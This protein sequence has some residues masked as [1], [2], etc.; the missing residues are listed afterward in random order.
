MVLGKHGCRDVFDKLGE[1]WSMTICGKIVLKLAHG[2]GD[3][4]SGEVG[5]WEMYFGLINW[6]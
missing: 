3:Y 5:G 6:C 1:V 4:M 2:C